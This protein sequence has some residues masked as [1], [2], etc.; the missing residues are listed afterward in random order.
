MLSDKQQDLMQQVEEGIVETG[1]TI[2]TD[3]VTS[4]TCIR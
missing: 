3:Q 2:V 4:T 1:E